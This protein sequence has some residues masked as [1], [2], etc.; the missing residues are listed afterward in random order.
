MSRGVEARQHIGTVMASLLLLLMDLLLLPQ[1]L[2]SR[3]LLLLLLLRTTIRRRGVSIFSNRQ[4]QS[5]LTLEYT[6][7]GSCVDCNWHTKV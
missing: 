6:R 5:K 3:D 7:K 2:F 4:S 1:G